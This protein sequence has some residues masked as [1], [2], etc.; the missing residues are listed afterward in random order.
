MVR[1]LL[2]SEQQPGF[3]IGLH[4]IDH[5]RTAIARVTVHMLKQMQ[6]SSAPTVESLHIA[7]FRIHGIEPG[8]IV[9]QGAQF[10][11]ACLGHDCLVVDG[12]QQVS[13]VGAE[14]LARVTQQKGQSA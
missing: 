5:G 10:F 3:L 11:A 2:G 9:A 14:L 4:Q 8:D 6:G 12:L 1:Q 13:Q 7:G